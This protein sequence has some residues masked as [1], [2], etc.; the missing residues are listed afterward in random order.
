[1]EFEWHETKE[2]INLR[3]HKIDFEFASAIFFDSNRIVCE[4]NRF[5]YQEK[6][7]ITFGKIAERL[8]V[9]VYTEEKGITRIIS[10]RKANKRERKYH[11]NNQIHT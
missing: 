2:K 11:E 6:R 8:H 3:K 1:M 7:L 4:D 9:V 5:D 10:A